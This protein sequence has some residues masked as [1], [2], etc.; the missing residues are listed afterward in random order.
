[1]IFKLLLS[2]GL[3]ASLAVWCYRR[4]LPRLPWVSLIAQRKAVILKDDLQIANN[5]YGMRADGDFHL[6][7]A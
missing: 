7:V 2:G 6:E 3:R 5:F 4:T 1:V